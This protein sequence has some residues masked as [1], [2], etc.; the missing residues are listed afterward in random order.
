MRAKMCALVKETA[1]GVAAAM[2]ASAEV[3]VI[4]GYPGVVNTDDMTALVERSM[5]ALVGKE[6]VLLETVPGMGTEDFGAFFMGRGIPGCYAHFGFGDG[7]EKCVHPAHGSRFLVN[8]DGLPYAAALHAA[9]V[10]DYLEQ[11]AF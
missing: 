6:N 9:V 3:T 1:E 11:T 2:G 5:T 7:G 8:E 4:E 10:F